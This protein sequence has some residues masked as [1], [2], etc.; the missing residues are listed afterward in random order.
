M[1]ED[2]N[3]MKKRTGSFLLALALV[4]TLFGCAQ[5]TPAPAA[6][7]EPS[8]AAQTP[9]KTETPPEV[10][11]NGGCYV[12]VDDKVYFR[13][14]GKDALEKTALFGQFTD[15]W[16]T[17]GSELM[18][19]D[20]ATG[21]LDT[22]CAESGHGP[23]WYADGGF[24]LR[25]RMAGNDYVVWHA[26]DGSDSETICP[27]EPLGVTESGLLAVQTYPTDG[28]GWRDYVFYREKKEVGALRG[29]EIYCT[30]AGLT[31]DGLFLLDASYGEEKQE[32][33]LYQ[34]TVDGKLLRLGALPLTE[35]DGVEPFYD[36]QVDRFAAAGNQIAFGVGYYMGTGH[37][38]GETVFVQATVG[39]ENSLRDL[40]VDPSEERDFDMPRLTANEGGG[41]S[42]VP[43]LPGELRVDMDA[44][45]NSPL[46]LYENGAWR[47]LVPDFACR[48]NDGY[49]FRRV[50]QHLD[51]VGGR[52]YVTLAC[53]HA[54]PM[55]SIGWR[56]AYALL[57]MIYLAVEPDGTTKEIACVDHD[58]TLYGDVWFIEGESMALWRQRRAWGE[59][60]DVSNH[61]CIIPIA[62]DAEWEN[63][64]EAVFDGVTGLLPGDYGENEADYYG[65]PLP[66]DEPAGQL[67]L[68]LDRDGNI[69][70]LARRTPETLLAIKF[71]VPESELAGAA[72]K[73]PLERRENDEDTKWFWAKLIALEDGVRVRVERTPDEKS[74]LDYVAEFDGAFIVGETLCD[75]TLDRG[76]FVAVRVS[77]PWHPEL[78]VS[79][80]KDGAWGAYVFGEDNWMHL[81]TEES[82][83]PESTVEAHPEP[84]DLLKDISDGTWVCRDSETGETVGVMS[85]DPEGHLTVGGEAEGYTFDIAFE[86]L[87]AEL[88]ESCDLLCLTNTDDKLRERY[89]TSGGDYLVEL[90]HTGEEDV[91]YLL[92]ANN[93]DAALPEAFRFGRE[94]PAYSFTLTRAQGAGAAY[95]ARL[96]GTTFV[97]EAVRY[98]EESGV[99][100]LR[101]AKLADDGDEVI[102]SVWRAKYAAP[103]LAYPVTGADALAE[104][105]HAG[106]YPVT[107]YKV[108]VNSAGEVESL[109]SL[110]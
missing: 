17:G 103:C 62:K 45:G 19:Y 88:W 94:E 50:E 93:G 32:N 81:W 27:G 11:N 28:I 55:D 6:A 67:S 76:E 74:G 96:R 95:N 33:T 24:Y 101:E 64:W 2:K 90:T 12:R 43:A 108:T 4:L 29:M 63:G 80:S 3:E 23:L 21:T 14:Y 73:L 53:A 31:D 100:W 104:L 60:Y 79:V 56:D 41:F 48:S 57:D 75:K 35:S 85:F 89:G 8:P 82:V 68:K 38:L 102:G 59:E 47:T 39:Q 34:V 15:T 25:E 106:A 109:S 44:D 99:V 30:F 13:R 86:R 52:A 69:V 37:F 10:E 54:S 87:Y 78:R 61:G 92:Q 71:D 1:T 98:E 49:G 84:D 16:G 65:Y 91:L 5:K 97:A 51:Y 77:L 40:A 42:V 107:M 110:F 22:V 105:Q 18:A 9:A 83:H 70:R 20:P 46:E 36:V 7:T 26:L 58:A 72:E 66:E